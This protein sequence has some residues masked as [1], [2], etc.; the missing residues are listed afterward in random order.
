MLRQITQRFEIIKA[1]ALVSAMCV[2]MSVL[3]T[4]AAL[5]LTGQPEWSFILLLAIL[6]PA[7]IAPPISY[8]YSKLLH[9]LNSSQVI[10]QHELQERVKA[11][12]LAQELEVRLCQVLDHT[13]E[14]LCMASP[15]FQKFYYASS[16]YEKIW[17]RSIESVYAS[18]VSFLKSVHKEDRQRVL[19]ELTAGFHNEEREFEFRIERTDGEIRWVRTRLLTVEDRSGGNPRAVGF[20]S[21]ITER[22]RAE[23]ELAAQRAK[24]VR[25]VWA[26]R[27]RAPSSRSSAGRSSWIP[28][29]RA[30]AR[31]SSSLFR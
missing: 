5:A 27:C 20:S 26:C 12:E 17:G 29:T 7:S 1:A 15:D 16:A 23:T 30:A 8:S 24:S 19:K 31:L 21:D 10:L 9:E 14:A 28:S 2:A 18:P 11:H 4:L 6:C 22:K 25:A 3:I 13:S